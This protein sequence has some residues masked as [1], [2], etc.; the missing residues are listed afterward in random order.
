MTSNKIHSSW[1]FPTVENPPANARNTGLIPGPERFHMPWHHSQLSL[2]A[3]TT[4]AQAL[5]PGFCNKR[6]HYNEKPSHSNEE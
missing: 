3:T 4:E 2:C 6:S 1:D 5:E